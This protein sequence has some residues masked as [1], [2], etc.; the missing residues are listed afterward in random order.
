MTLDLLASLRPE[1]AKSPD[2][3]ISA[4][5]HYARGKEG[6]IPL[7]VGEGDLPTPDFLREAASRSLAAG[8]TYYTWSRG[9]PE[10]REALAR[11]V[12]RLHGRPSDPERFFVTGSGMQ[13]IQIALTLVAG[14][15]DE[16]I[17]PSPAWPN[18]GAAVGVRGATPVPVPLSFGNDGWTLDVTRLADAVTPATRAIF[19]NSPSNPT[20]W[21]ATPEDIR[22]VLDLA[23]ARGLW[24]VADEVYGRF[25]YGDRPV[26]PSFHDI[27]EPDDR[28]LYVN[29][30]SKNW[31]MTGW[32]IGWL[33]APVALGQT[34]E[35]LIQ[36][37]TSGTAVFMQR[38]AVAALETG[39]DFVAFQLDRA[40]RSREILCDA[41][42]RTGR[43][44]LARPDGAFYL[45]FGVEGLD[46]SREAAFRLI[47]EAK[48][49][50]APGSAF[51]ADGNGFL[52]L[53]YARSPE[54]IAVAAERLA[55]WLQRRN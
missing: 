7:W 14:T 9:I 4:V 41:L 32:R 52:R 42:E 11:Y 17:M 54:S 6:V 43:V 12:T 50:L 47:D 48:V 29:T 23:R 31:A 27:A 3:G 28:I 36:Y 1:A 2:S 55:G 22:A 46:D 37:S 34:I 33:E 19:L 40:R 30:F 5:R 10:L 18:C 13:A 25:V 53:C 26:A 49:G 45:F 35:N 21:T 16:V 24:I 8:E 38:A 20:G 15:G 44:R 39:E 51:G